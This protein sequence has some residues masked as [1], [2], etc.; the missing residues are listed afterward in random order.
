VGVVCDLG[1]GVVGVGGWRAGED[2]DEEWI[3]GV[4]GHS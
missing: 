4:D 3:L 1:G 2:L